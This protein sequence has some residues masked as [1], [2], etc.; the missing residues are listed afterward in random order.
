M[1]FRLLVVAISVLY[2]DAIVHKSPTNVSPV[3]RGCPSS[4]QFMPNF[5]FMKFSGVWYESF[6][7]SSQFERGKCLTMNV[8]LPEKSK[9]TKALITLTYKISGKKRFSE[10]EQN[11]TVTNITSIWSFYNNATL[12]GE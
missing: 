11:V 2:S 10:L 9:P 5:D 6:K 1:K 4:L 8:S 7:Y 3:Y 12:S